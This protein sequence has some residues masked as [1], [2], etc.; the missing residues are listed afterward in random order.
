MIGSIASPQSAPPCSPATRWVL[1]SH[2]FHAALLRA[3]YEAPEI[4]AAS[5]LI[6]ALEAADP[7]LALFP[8]VP[9]TIGQ[10]LAERFHVWGLGLLDAAGLR[11]DG[12]GV[13]TVEASHSVQAWTRRYARA[14]RPVCG[15][16]SGVLA[17]LLEEHF[18]RSVEVREV[19]CAA[20]GA[21]QCRFEVSAGTDRRAEGNRTGRSRPSRYGLEST[22][23]SLELEVVPLDAGPGAPFVALPAEFYAAISRLFE[24]EVPRLRGAKFASLPGIMLM[25][26]AHRNGF[27]LLG[28][29]LAES[30]RRCGTSG[31]ATEHER[32]EYLFEVVERL[33]WGQWRMQSFMPGERLIVRIFGSYEGVSHLRVWGRDSRPRCTVALGAAA[34]MMNLLY[35]V[36]AGPLPTLDPSFYN[37]LFRNPHS[38]RASETR[39]VACGD[40]YCE[41]VVNP[42]TA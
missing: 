13:V 29:T 42:L 3:L 6:R 38:F 1:H 12:T 2:H 30:E 37:T 41:V 28:E 8:P 32:L 15:I 39:C 22:P 27:H 16:A 18:G 35:R 40:E 10:A 21:K 24:E 14:K 36:P 4:D 5:L 31:G 26:A 23:G 19:E 7:G 34:A 25:E 33:G 11:P 9:T 20:M 17:R